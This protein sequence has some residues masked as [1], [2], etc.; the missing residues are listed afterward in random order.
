MGFGVRG[1]ET[2]LF[3]RSVG[4][5]RLPFKVIVA[6]KLVSNS[7]HLKRPGFDLAV[8]G[9]VWNKLAGVGRI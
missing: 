6:I 9:I 3:L 1:W 5:G 4:N 7:F 8:L 2:P